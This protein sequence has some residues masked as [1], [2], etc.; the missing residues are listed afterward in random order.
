MNLYRTW[1]RWGVGSVRREQTTL[2]M[3]LRLRGGGGCDHVV[4]YDALAYNSILLKF[5]YLFSAILETAL[6]VSWSYSTGVRAFKLRG[7]YRAR[8]RVA[9]VAPCQR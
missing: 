6:N 7:C 5:S 3:G 8:L 9:C 2:D 4:L 1:N